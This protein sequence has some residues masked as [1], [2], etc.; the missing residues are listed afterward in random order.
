MP[1]IKLTSLDLAELQKLTR[2]RRWDCVASFSVNERGEVW[3]FVTRGW[4]K[5]HKR[6]Y[7]L[8]ECPA[9]EQIAEALLSVR[10]EGGRILLKSDGAYYRLAVGADVL[11]AQVELPATWLAKHQPRPTIYCPPDL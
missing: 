7:V 2:K 9:V 3:M 6:K 11:F 4:T 8:G 1:T 5:E 10:P